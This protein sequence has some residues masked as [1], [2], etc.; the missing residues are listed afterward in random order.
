MILMRH[1]QSEFNVVFAESRQDPGI[2]DP[3]L[4]AEGRRQVERALEHLEG[5]RLRR[6]VTSPYTR[7]LETADIVARGLG[8]PVSVDARV[9]ERAKFACDIGAPRSRLAQD[10]PALSFATIDE[11]WWPDGEEPDAAVASRCS[12]FCAA[13]A[14]CEDWPEVLVVC[15][16]GIILELTGTRA[17]N[18]QT[19]RFDPVA[20]RAEA[21]AGPAHP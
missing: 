8:L 15:H 11:V 2:V 7:A 10:W 19:L 20:G 5:Q 1:G 12:A 3:R 9:R 13:M 16:W 17:T 4:T 14:A 21:L 6:I 18:A